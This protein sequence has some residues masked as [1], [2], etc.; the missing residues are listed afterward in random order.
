M[1]IRRGSLKAVCIRT[2]AEESVDISGNEE[3]LAVGAF[4]HREACECER[5]IVEGPK[6]G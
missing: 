5:A 1:Y 2:S 3:V 4:L 6:Q